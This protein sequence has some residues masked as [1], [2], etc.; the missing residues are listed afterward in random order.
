MA[1]R[2]S[3][4]G[5]LGRRDERQ[6]LDELLAG[7]RAGQSATLVLR[8]EPGIGKTALLTYLRAQST[9]C[10]VVR[11]AGVQSEM[12]LSYAGLH[13]L[14]A[15]LLT[16]LDQLPG[17]QR[18]ALATAFG[19]HDGEPPS[20]F[21]VG[22]ATLSLLA[23]A[24]GNQP[25]VCL[26]DDAQW[27]DHASAQTLQFVA[28]RLLAESILLVFAVRDPSPGETF[29]GL[30]ELHLT[31]LSDSDSRTLLASVVTGP[32]DER[33]RDRIVAET[34]GNPLA[35]LEL[36]RGLAVA[37][38]AGGFVRPDAP[39]LSSQLEQGFLRRVQLLP[40]E[41]Q[42]LLIT[43]AAEPVGDVTLLWRAAE[44]LGI[45][46]DAAAAQAE[47]SGLITFGARVRFR[48]PLVRSAAYRAA[49][50]YERREIHH[51]L[52]EETDPELDPDR[53]AWHL[54]RA[55]AG[56][57]EAVAAELERSADRAQS[58][59]GVAA[60]AAFL[61][62]AAQLTP[63]PV[64]RGARTLAAAQAKFEAGAFEAGLALAGTAEL[65]PLDA[66]GTVK[67]TLLR[68]RIAALTQGMTVALPLFLDAA[69]RFEVLDPGLALST[70]REAIVTSLS[71]G[72]LSRKVAESV[73]SAPKPDQPTRHVLLLEG[74]AQITTAGYAAGAPMVLQ[75]LAGLS[76]E[77]QSRQEVLGWYQLAGRLATDVWDFGSWSVLSKLLVDVAR[78]TG[79]L[80]VLA[81]ALLLRLANRA[82]AGELTTAATL[83][84]EVRTVGE[85]TG[86]GFWPH[87]G[88]MFLEPW[89]GR[90]AQTQ[91]AITTITDRLAAVRGHDKVL[92]DTQWAA[93][94]L[95]NG[96]SRYDVAYAAAKQASANPQELGLSLHALAEFA[97]AAA[98]LGRPA[99]AADAVR[100]LV[101]MAQT[102]GTGWAVG[103]AAFARALVSEGPAAEDSYREAIERFDATEVRMQLAR[104]RLCYGEWLRREGRRVD[105]RAQ[106]GA[107]H[108]MLTGFGAEGFA[109]RARRELQAT[110]ATVRK[111]AVAT[112]D[113]LTAQ[114]AQ[115][116][117][118]AADGLTNP[119]IGAR[120]FISP[121]T[122]EW[123]LRKVFT[124][125]GIT[126]RREI[127]T[128]L[129]PG[130]ASA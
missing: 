122:V 94:V 40:T 116:A 79:T 31:G 130:T 59:G 125:L 120:L 15:P 115:I 17:P 36:P 104:V 128:L 4:A 52:A 3:R 117:R 97:E 43:A 11:A 45:A 110:G 103:T 56:P 105:A 35:L 34:G 90:E 24:G 23:D 32:L 21:L 95:Y 100:A 46:V 54:A 73:L 67:L 60:A 111:P 99:D 6:A 42:R 8:G 25:L 9:G 80:P 37:E 68:G 55:A 64:R 78:E 75:A 109:E 101:E 18:D 88:P 92:A 98:R 20:R 106:L 38:I 127:A 129:P 108:E 41:T 65:S 12:E 58:R 49:N 119:E 107:A 91:Q 63:D 76:T 26:I 19:L 28:R 72:G 82:L 10:R 83:A 96:L 39:P 70:Y 30:P 50:L 85:A 2:G 114:E 5:L 53:R 81:P 48:H 27:L 61:D 29:P 22:L 124:K 113:A 62:R 121:H 89:R 71:G 123:H 86:S 84:E 126:S 112:V 44:R 118:L 16:G 93:A 51:A 102:T 57:N 69:K 13:Q 87:Y 7:A 14:C 77:G 1:T 47:A 33:V 66:L 74:L